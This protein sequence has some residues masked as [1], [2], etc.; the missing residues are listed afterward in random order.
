MA[1]ITSI[2]KTV[3]FYL[4]SRPDNRKIKPAPGRRSEILGVM[5]RSEDQGVERSYEFNGKS[6]GLCVG[7]ST[8]W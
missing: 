3:I 7:E 2:R 8:G 4:L 6:D 5:R 1:M